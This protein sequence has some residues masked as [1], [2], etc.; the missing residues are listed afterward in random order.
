MDK[1]SPPRLLVGGGGEEGR[2]ARTDGRDERECNRLAGVRLAQH[3]VPKLDGLGALRQPCSSVSGSVSTLSV[4]TKK[5]RGDDIP[6]ASSPGLRHSAA[7]SAC[8]QCAA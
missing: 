3:R 6:R 5:A 1:A 2:L 8:R 4:S 7:P